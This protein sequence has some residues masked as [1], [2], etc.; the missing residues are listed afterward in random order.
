MLIICV[1]A[2]RMMTGQ[3]D[4]LS[5]TLKHRADEQQRTRS[6]ASSQLPLMP[7]KPKEVVVRLHIG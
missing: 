5:K 4:L 2:T 6:I 1:K 7:D 3:G